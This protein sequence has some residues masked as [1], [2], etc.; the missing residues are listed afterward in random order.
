MKYTTLVI[1]ALIAI[2]FSFKN[3]KLLS[4]YEIEVK[5]NGTYKHYPKKGDKVTVHYVGTLKDGRK[6]DSSRDRN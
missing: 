5:N 4:V 6:F 2:V 1:F 3:S